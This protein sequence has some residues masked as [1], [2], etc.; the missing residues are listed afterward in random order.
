M[1]KY[2]GIGGT[3]YVDANGDV[4]PDDVTKERLVRDHPHLVPHLTQKVSVDF[5]KQKKEK[6]E[7]VALP[8]I[9]GEQ[10]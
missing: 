8:V 4:Q 9:E 2:E 1:N 10:L 7:P 5:K 3:F 6:D